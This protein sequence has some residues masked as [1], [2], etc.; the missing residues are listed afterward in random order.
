[1]EVTCNRMDRG[2]E[3]YQ[4]EL[5]EKALAVLRSGSYIMGNELDSF[6]KE[7]AAFLGS[8][9]CVGVGNGLSALAIAFH[10]LGIGRGDEVVVPANTYIASVLGITL[11]GATPVFVEPDVYYNIDTTQIEERI[12]KS[13]KAI[14]A[15]HLYGQPSNMPEIMLIAEKYGLR[16]IEDCAQSHGA[17]IGQ[18]Q[19]GTFGDIGCFSFYP[20]KNLGAFGDGGA[21]VTDD[22]EL[23][24][25]AR[26]FR[27]YGSRIK[28]YNEVM[29]INSRLDEIQAGLLR[30]KLSHLTEL[31]TEREQLA[32]FYREYIKNKNLI[33][34]EVRSGANSVWHQYVVRTKN[35]IQLLERLKKKGIA[36]TIHYP[37]PPHL[38]GALEY[39]G[40]REGDY[41][42]T[43]RYAR[44]VVSLP[45]YNGMHLEEQQY[46]VD[47]LNEEWNE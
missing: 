39:L 40:F 42:V 11:N 46:V 31:N 4:E 6:E 35:R 43:E 1:M 14:L 34:P 32:L 13:T 16:V 29:G 18:R 2:Y 8:K 15:V 3:M 47:V 20:T 22:K 7:F 33:L 19:T 27:N 5:E 24:E 36:A 21:L 17:K 45:F 12:T 10:L 25:Q 26:T 30:V 44:E 38:S 41:P 23:A 9:H 37:V 28:Y